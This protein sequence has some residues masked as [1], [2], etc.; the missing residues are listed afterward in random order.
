MVERRSFGNRVVV[1][2]GGGGGIGAALGRAF[3]AEGARVALLD[4]DTGALGEAVAALP[5]GRAMGIELDVCDEEACE[6]VMDQV[7]ST[8]GG[9]DVLINNAGIS[10]RS[11]FADT[12]ASVVRRVMEV[13]FFGS[14][15]CTAAALSS[16]TTRKGLIIAISSV[17]GFAPLIGR[18]GYCASKH[19]LHGFYGSLRT[20]LR[21]TG[22]EV[23]MVCPSFI[24]TKI[25]TR[26]LSGTGDAIGDGPRAKCVRRS[27]RRRSRRGRSPGPAT[28]SATAPGPK[29]GRSCSPTR[30]PRRSSPAQRAATVCSR[31]R[32]SAEAPGGSHASRRSSTK[33]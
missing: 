5:K 22:A 16:I 12:E 14:V 25:E 33:H 13:N 30:S 6:A 18:T 27:S 9:I 8:W 26:A 31:R 20:E 28:P 11:L 15:N 24:A 10:H 7:C 23:M 4:R 3:V 1:I 21:G 2:T 17:A 32:R 29:P 19:A